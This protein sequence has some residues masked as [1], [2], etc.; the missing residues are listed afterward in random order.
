M[1]AP[2]GQPGLSFL[3][4]PL[5]SQGSSF[6]SQEQTISDIQPQPRQSQSRCLQRWRC[7]S[8]EWQWTSKTL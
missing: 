3:L 8:P 5:T 6:L 1:D 2:P 4:K 7:V